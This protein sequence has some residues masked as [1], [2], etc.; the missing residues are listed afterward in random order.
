MKRSGRRYP[1]ARDRDGRDQ[2]CPY[3]YENRRMRAAHVGHAYLSRLTIRHVTYEDFAM[4]RPS[5]AA[6]PKKGDFACPDPSFL[7]TYPALAKGLCDPWWDDGKPR[8]CWTLKIWFDDAGVHVCVNDPD[9]KMVAFTTHSGLTEALAEL[10]AAIE[11]DTLS[12][13]KSKY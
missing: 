6:R 11:A 5:Q 4:K 8:K 13:R 1:C 7:A 10:D 9:S 2:W 3:C 12:W